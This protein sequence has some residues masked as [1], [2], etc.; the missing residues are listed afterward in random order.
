M[1]RHYEIFVYTKGT[2]LYAEMVCLAIR[3]KYHEILEETKNFMSFRILSR[4]EDP[5]ISKKKLTYILP[6]LKDF[7]LIL[8]DRRDV[9]AS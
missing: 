8:D 2:R 6:T 3:K 5:D 7:L 4:D 9:T 1:I